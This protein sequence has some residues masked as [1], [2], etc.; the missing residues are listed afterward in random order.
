MGVVNDLIDEQQELANVKHPWDRYH[1][2]VANWVLP[3]TEQF[4]TLVNTGSGAGAI[5]S[6]VNQPVAS[7]RSKHIYDMTSLWAIDRLTAGLISLKTPE[8]DFWH[9]LNVDDDF[10]YQPSFTQGMGAVSRA[11]TKGGE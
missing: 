6:V 8:S 11:E 3:H 4:D 10:G 2:N 9:D 1:R 5:M 7:D